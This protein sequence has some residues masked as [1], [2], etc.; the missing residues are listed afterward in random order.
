MITYQILNLDHVKQL[1]EIDRSE[2]IDLIYEVSE[3][4]LVEHKQDHEC[5]NWGQ[6]QLEEMQDRYIY[7]LQQGGMAYG[8]FDGTRLVGFG[9]LAHQFRGKEQNQLQLDLMYVSRAYRR[10]GIGTR[11]LA[12]LSEEARR[13]GARSLYIS[14]TETR[15]AVSFYQSQGSEM[16]GEADEELYTKEPKDIHMVKELNG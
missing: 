13:R 15:S 10:Q 9:V 6:E 8:A 3:Q 5:A 2:Y 4:G 1:H 16:T 11:I 7:E 14:S 12:F